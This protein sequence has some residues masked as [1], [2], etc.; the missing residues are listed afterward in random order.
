MSSLDSPYYDF[1]LA[2]PEVCRELCTRLSAVKDACLKA[3]RREGFLDNWDGTRST[4]RRQV[5][6]A[7]TRALAAGFSFMDQR[8]SF[9]CTGFEIRQVLELSSNRGPSS[10]PKKLACSE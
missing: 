7:I 5:V 9:V 3:E 4:D 8:N 2:I 10:P 1:R 6:P